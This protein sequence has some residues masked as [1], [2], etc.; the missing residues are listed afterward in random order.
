MV[1]VAFDNYDKPEET[2]NDY[3]AR[4][5]YLNEEQKIDEDLN[6]AYGQVGAGIAISKEFQ[7]N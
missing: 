7:E 6:E 4:Q 2:I 3:L 1:V 5:E